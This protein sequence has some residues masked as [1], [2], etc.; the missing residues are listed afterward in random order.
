[1]L[2]GK[3]GWRGCEIGEEGL[4]IGEERTCARAQ[5]LHPHPS[6]S[7]FLQDSYLPA[8]HCSWDFQLIGGSWSPKAHRNT[9]PPP[10]LDRKASLHCTH[11]LV[12]TTVSSPLMK[13]GLRDVGAGRWG[14]SLE[15]TTSQWVE[16][17]SQV[18]DAECNLEFRGLR[19]LVWRKMDRG[20]GESPVKAREVS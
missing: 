6:S 20:G 18:W 9:P 8:L 7:P 11:T 1:M 14:E 2:A 13:G 12:A 17:H 19:A 3:K 15:I 5:L 4:G 16:S 10:S